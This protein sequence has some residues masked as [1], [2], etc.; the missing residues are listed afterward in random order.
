LNSQVVIANA[1][2][3]RSDAFSSILSLASIAL[4][5]IFPGLLIADS[6]AGLFVAGYFIYHLM[7]FHCNESYSFVGR[8]E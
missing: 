2:H 1:W 3:H 6:A 4:A 7:L 5:I 8:K